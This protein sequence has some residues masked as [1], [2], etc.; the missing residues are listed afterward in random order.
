MKLTLYINGEFIDNMMTQVQPVYNHGTVKQ[1]F[2]WLKSLNSSLRGQTIT[3]NIRLTLQ[4]LRGR[5]SALW[6]R[7]WDVASPQF[8]ESAGIDPDLQELLLR[9]AK[10]GTNSE[11][12]EGSS[13]RI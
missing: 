2:K 3:E 4:I 1:Y 8:V 6:Q 13:S 10:N 9:N 5:D 12:F 7:D 11:C